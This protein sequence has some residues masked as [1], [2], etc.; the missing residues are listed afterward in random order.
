MRS[1]SRL[2]STL[3]ETALAVL[4]VLGVPLLSAC[5]SSRR[6]VSCTQTNENGSLSL[7][8]SAPSEQSQVELLEITMKYPHD[9]DQQLTG[10]R[11]PLPEGDSDG[12]KTKSA[13]IADALAQTLGIQADLVKVKREDDGYIASAT[14][15]NIPALF[16]SLGLSADGLDLDEIEAALE[17]DAQF[18]C[19]PE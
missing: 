18:A 17:Q 12:S 15:Q 7:R 3:S 14:I 8:M 9:F 16:A 10:Y 6:T 4:L 2:S 5:G 13:L 19:L 11:V 1:V